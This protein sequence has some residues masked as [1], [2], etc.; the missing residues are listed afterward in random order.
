MALQVAES[1]PIRR[2]GKIKAEFE[3]NYIDWQ[4]VKTGVSSTFCPVTIGR[5]FGPNRKGGWWRAA[6]TEF[7]Q[8]YRKKWGRAE[9]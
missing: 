6:L 7:E 8:I 1:E 5:E 4:L 2:A 3:K 9:Y